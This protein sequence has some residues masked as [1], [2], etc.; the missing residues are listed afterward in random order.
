MNEQ[1]VHITPTANGP[2]QVEG[3]SSISR[4]GDEDDIDISPRAF[5]CRCG[6]SSNK[7]FC[8]GTHARNG[9]SSDKDPTRVPDQR[10]DYGAGNLTIHDNRGLCAH[11]GRCTDN[12]AS[13]F[14]LGTA[15]QI[16]LNGV[17]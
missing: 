14:R 17:A 11:A 4:M 8:D 9:F 5:L 10:D 6:G 15:I 13:V 16:K 2:Y 7:P 1:Q 12:L 3:A